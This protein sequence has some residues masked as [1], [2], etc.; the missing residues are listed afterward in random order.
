[1][2][3][4]PIR[5]WTNLQL[6]IGPE[7]EDTVSA[8]SSRPAD[9]RRHLARVRLAQ[10]PQRAPHRLPRRV[11]HADI[12]RVLGE[13]RGR[14]VAPVALVDG[15]VDVER[16]GGVAEADVLDKAELAGATS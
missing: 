11:T 13:I 12:P 14:H 1:M 15:D 2:P 8:P 5:E 3:P 10:A 16:Q 4:C 6:P 9:A 7:R